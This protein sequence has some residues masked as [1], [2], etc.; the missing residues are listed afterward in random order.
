[1]VSTGPRFGPVK[2]F[3]GNTLLK[4]IPL[5]G[6]AETKRLKNVAT[7]DEAR[8]GRLRIVVAKNK[9]VRIEGLAVVTEP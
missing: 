1:M 9:Q 8:S 5:Q 6:G 3:L 7:F 2:V 4:K